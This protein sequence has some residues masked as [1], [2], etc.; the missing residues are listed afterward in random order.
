[1]IN[2]Y[3]NIEEIENNAKEQIENYSNLEGINKLCVFPDIHFCDEKAI[4]VGVSFSTE[5]IFYPLVT[6][7][8]LGCGVMYLK[9]DKKDLLK[10]FDKNQHYQFLERSHRL[11]TNDGLGGGNHFLSIEED[12]YSIYI[13]CHTGSRN[14]GIY[15]YQKNYDLINQYN[16]KNNLNTKFID[17]DFVDNKYWEEYNNILKFA[18]LRRKNF[19][20]KTLIW[21]QNANYIVC[22]KKEIPTNY[23]NNKY[24]DLKLEDYLYGTKYKIEDSDHNLLEKIDNTIIH[25]K[26]ATKLVKDR[27]VV[28]PLSMSR[29]SLLVKLQDEWTSNEALNSC[30]HGAGRKLSRFD[31]MKFWRTTLKEKERKQYK[32]I[33]SELLDNSGNFPNGYLQEFDYAYK[34]SEDILKNQPY[35]KKITQTNP[36][37]TIKFT[38]I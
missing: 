15:F 14:L 1:M 32:E 29:G 9:I 27:I 7:K 11:M 35:I 34:D 17:L 18:H 12:D 25:R 3:C 21:L 6:G 38:E 19:C 28:I 20:I 5:N 30:S 23:L 24:D 4:P 10:K 31:A 2:Y 33:F 37:V 16:N 22:N 13:I 8:D 36:I 26:G